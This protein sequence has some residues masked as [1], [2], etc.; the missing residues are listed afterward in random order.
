MPGTQ[1]VAAPTR[2]LEGVQQAPDKRNVPYLIACALLAVFA[3]GFN[4]A[5]GHRGVFLLDQSMIFDGGWRLLQGQTMYKDF[6]IPFGPITFCIQAL[7]FL[8][9]GVNWAATVAPACAINMLATL[10]VIRMVRLLSGG[11]RVVALA[12]GLA[13]AICFQAPF[14]TLWLEQTAMFFDLLALQ[15]MLE[16]LQVSGRRRMAFQLA[17]GFSLALAVL[18]K[19]N[20]GVFF[21]P[22]VLIAAA[23]ELPD[24]RRVFRAVLFAGMALVATLAVFALWVLAFSDLSSFVQS[25]LVTASEIGRTRMT[26]EV[27]RNALTFETVPRYLQIDLIAVIAGVIALVMR[28]YLSVAGI[29][30]LLA[31]FRS[32][33][34]ATT[35]NEW[36]NNFAFVGLA[37]GLGI[38]LLVRIR[39]GLPVSRGGIRGVIVGLMVAGGIWSALLL[40]YEAIAAW[41]RTVQQFAP[42]SRFRDK[43]AV[44]GMEAVYWGEPTP[45]RK[46]STLQ[47]SEFEGVFEYLS[48]TGKPFFVMGD[49]SILY[50]LLGARS[51]QPLLYFLPG[52]SFLLE[53]IPRLDDLVVSSLERNGVSVVIR[54]KATHLPEIPHAYPQFPR[55]WA[56]FTSRFVHAKDIG[57]YEVWEQRAVAA[58]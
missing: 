48:E 1:G 33:T 17:S 53:H 8:I 13:T 27:M 9:F 50:G 23:A 7:S 21:V 52:H 51:P 14:G 32:F 29:A 47:R 46:V 19:Q 18:S 22:V 20:Y 12:S 41:D 45:L 25:V 28:R 35:L 11:S 15:A 4:W 10:S 34:Q 24:V 39:G 43:V 38:G 58:R 55:T 31:Y 49:S 2:P 56:W 42:G 44:R 40:R 5:T 30:I 26:S 6:I 3:F 57:N 54:E 16:S 36:E 37:A